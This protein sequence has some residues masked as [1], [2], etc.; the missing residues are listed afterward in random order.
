MLVLFLKLLIGHAFCD[1]A[2]QPTA[3][4]IG[5][6]KTKINQ[7]NPKSG[8]GSPDWYYWLGAHTLI[9]GGAVWLITG[10]VYI[11]MTEIILHWIIDQMKCNNRTKMHI[12]QFLHIAC[13]V[14]Y[15]FFVT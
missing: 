3:M 4:A 1:F 6:C 15:V 11:G 13:K 7:K 12:D 2:L 9:H 5:K 10:N 8:E 14:I